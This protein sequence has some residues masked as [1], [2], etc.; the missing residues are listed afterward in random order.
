VNREVATLLVALLLLAAPAAAQISSAPAP[1]QSPSRPGPWAVDI[2]G[3]TGPVPGTT[4][5]YPP[6]DNT[7]RVP[8]RGF[9]IDFGAHVYVLNLGPS[10]VGVGVNIVNVRATTTPIVE[11][12]MPATTPTPTTTPTPIPTTTPVTTTAGQTVQADLRML[13]PQISFNFGSREGW[14][15]L[16]AGAGTAEIVT[17][18]TGVLSGRR[19]SGRLN[20]LNFGAGARWFIKSHLA[21]GFDVRMYTMSAGS[22]TDVSPPA[23]GEVTPTPRLRMLSVGAG[24]SVR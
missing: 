24:F 13:A 10:R 19:E 6:L 8:A 11:A 2:R 14:S 18:T 5:F 3:V 17:R 23:G 9:G 15:Y 1:A 20:S 16:S 21:V 12:T 7:A 22:A 4:A